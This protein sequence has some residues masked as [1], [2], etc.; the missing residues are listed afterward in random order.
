M[1]IQRELFFKVANI[2]NLGQIVA[3]KFTKLSKTGFSKESFKAIFCDFPVQLFEFPFW[4]TYWALLIP[5]TPDILFKFSD[6][7]S[8]NF[9]GNS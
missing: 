1:L 8:P 9:I 5:D 3:D 4:L 7:L 2:R 6:L